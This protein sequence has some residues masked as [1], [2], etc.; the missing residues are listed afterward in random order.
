[1]GA[2]EVV[3]ES[4]SH[5]VSL[6]ELSTDQMTTIVRAWGARV[7]DLREDDR[8]EYALVFKNRGADAGAT[9]EHAHS[10]LIAIPF[11]PPFVREEL[12]GAHQ[13]WADHDRCPFCH[14]GE[15]VLDARERWVA[16][17]DDVLAY[18]PYASRFPFE[19]RVAPRRHGAHFEESTEAMGDAIADVLRRTLQ[20]LDR[21]LDRPPYNLVIHTAPFDEG[22]LDYYHWHIEIIPAL[23]YMAGFEWGTGCHINPTSPE[24]AAEHLRRVSLETPVA[25]A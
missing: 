12:E 10:Q 8:L 11:V 9:L 13:H 2:H 6:A 19:M 20:K 22:D 3:I 23:S 18:T 16:G 17:N 1:M 7:R 4:A 24:R 25:E 21:A 15:S 14:V 5:V